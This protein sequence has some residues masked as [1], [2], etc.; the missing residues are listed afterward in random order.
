[1]SKILLFLFVFVVSLFSSEQNITV[2]L[3]WKNQFEFAGYYVAKKKGF[4]K[5]VGLNV[6]LKEYH[7]GEDIEKEVLEGKAD[8]GIGYPTLIKDRAD[9]KKIVLLHTTFQTSPH[10]LVSGSD[11]KSI[12]EFKH[13]KIMINPDAAKSASFLA[14]FGVNDLRLSDMTQVQETFDVKD[15]VDKKCDIMSVYASDEIYTLKKLGFDYRIWNPADYGFDFY[16]NILY[17]SEKLITKNPE[18]VRKFN[19]AT[20]KGWEYAFEHIDETVDLIL[21]N[22][23]TQGK[24]RDALMYE[25]NVLKRFAFYHTEEFGKLKIDKLKRIYDVY[26]LLGYGSKKIDWDHFVY[27]DNKL[28]PNEV[29]WIKSNTIRVGVSPWFPITYYDNV[30]KKAGGIGIDILNIITKKFKL[31]IKYIPQ[32]WSVL[33]KLFK[34][35]KIDLL[36]TTYYTEQRAK[37]GDYTTA[38]MHITEAIYVRKNSHISGFD[39]LKGKKIAIVKAYGTIDKIKKRFPSIKIIEADTL[40]DT[41][42]LLLNGK[43]DAIFNTRFTVESYLRDHFIIGLKVVLQNDFASSPLYYFTN[44]Q[45]PILHSIM[46]KGVDYLKSTN[47]EDKILNKWL[48]YANKSKDKQVNFLSKAEKQW[49]R[50]HKTIKACVHPNWSPIEF[51]SDNSASEINGIAIDAIK[52]LLKKSNLK[53]ES[54]YTKSCAQSQE[55]LKEKKCDI[56]PAIAKTPDREKF[57]LFTEPFLSYKLAILS[58]IDKPFVE[59]IS[60]LY[61]KVIAKR[62]ESYLP[63]LIK[64]KYPKIKVLSTKNI[65]ESIEKVIDGSAYATI[66]PLPIVQHYI[67]EHSLSSVYIAGYMN[68]KYNLPVAVRKDMPILQSILNKSMKYVTKEEKNN[69]YH[70]WVYTSVKEKIDWK[71]MSIV[72]ASFLIVLV[73]VLIFLFRIRQI[74][75][76]LSQKI[77]QAVEENTAH[78]IKIQQQSRLAQMGEMLSMIAHQWRQ[79]LSAISATSATISLKAQLGNLDIDTAKEL[80]D[81]ISSYAQ[82]L[83]ATIADFRDFY[84]GKKEK[85]STSVDN[86]IESVMDIIEV[87]ITNKNIEIIKELNAKEKIDIYPNKLKQVILNLVKN[88]EDALIENMPNNPYIKIK[89]YRS[90]SQTIISVSDNAGGVPEEIMDRIFDPYFSTKSEKNGTGLGLYM[91]KIIIEDHCKGS[92]RVE[93]GNKGAIFTIILNT[94]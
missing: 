69:I 49:I 14:M 16:N 78:L 71:M 6:K 17:T 44:T 30:S 89:S 84:K 13:K 94:I 35:H 53:Y 68:E 25:A 11:I 74:N 64:R 65:L 86:V 59:D 81:K 15:L 40:A 26:K 58:K 52:M 28:T 7:A 41:I 87:S 66:A 67:N 21:A 93:N 9:G 75:K 20:K 24:S 36:P 85:K 12:K 29:D 76:K 3:L 8:F 83:S 73:V 79:P 22:Y 91:S 88:A 50:V 54:V 19:N 18:L 60:Q 80:S 92:L 90:K 70:K 55:F 37:Y 61:G 51:S 48:I 56:L 38:Y 32:K 39:D 23:N 10:V 82:H 45:K 46:Q 42:K 31:H 57:A 47:Y 4:Y 72:I 34:E 1:M 62:S 5:D 63:Q 43:V 27:R 2:D 33:L 77:E